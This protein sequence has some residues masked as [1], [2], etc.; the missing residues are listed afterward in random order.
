M[1]GKSGCDDTRGYTATGWYLG[2]P[3]PT[4]GVRL[5]CCAVL[6]ATV[7]ALG[8]AVLHATWNLLAK[9]SASPFVTMWGQFLVAGVISAVVIAVGGGL[10][11]AGWGYAAVTGVIHVPYIAGLA[12][13]YERGDF[14]LAYPI[15]RGG[16]ALVAGLGGIAL[17]GDDLTA[18]SL[19]AI[20]AMVGGIMLL[21][22]GAHRDQVVMAL[23]VAVTIGAYTLNDSRAIRV[24]D[25]D[26][27]AFAVFVGAA[28]PVSLYGIVTG[29]TGELIGALA[30]S[31]RRFVLMAV[32]AI[33]TYGLV[34]LAV[35]RA[36]VG[37][38]AALR[39]SS[40]VIA[41]FL[42]GRFLDEA[43]A[44]RRTIAATIVLA[45][46]VLLVISG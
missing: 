12:L 41:A 34:L 36:P 35:Q 15:A 26:L 6:V 9:Q 45:G 18:L 16:G 31:W 21:A 42:G 2:D 33:V 22:A 38:V 30:T 46:M 3:A 32:M 1:R 40:V 4:A 23:L 7:M 43:Q 24:L 29:R 37:Y 27:Y 39:E 20:L 44:H 8:A 25:D 17:L 13:A 5:R 10:P 14:S 19:L 28:I 11:A